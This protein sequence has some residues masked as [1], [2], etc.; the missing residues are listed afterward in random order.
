LERNEIDLTLSE[1]DVEPLVRDIAATFHEQRAVRISTTGGSCVRADARRLRQVLH[2]LI[3]N[4]VKYSPEDARVDV[5]IHGTGDR[6]QISVTD[7]GIG[8]PKDELGQV[9][10]RFSRASNARQLGIAG[11]GFGLYL[12]RQIVDLHGGTLTVSSTEGQ[13][14]TFTVDL[15]VAPHTAPEHPLSIAVLDAERESRSFIA[16]AL[17][18]AGLRVHVEHS[19]ENLLEW[20]A[21]NA[22]DSVVLDVDDLRLTADQVGAIERECERSGFTI[23]A[24]GIAGTNLFERSVSLAKPFLVQDLLSALGAIRS[25]PA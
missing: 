10:G 20:L 13:G 15:P 4:A 7:R 22:V 5:N 6:L 19:V 25:R 21:S 14:S 12:A 2:N 11:T 1:V 24:V 3:E 8:I 17:R 9:F 16:H 23:V 18:E